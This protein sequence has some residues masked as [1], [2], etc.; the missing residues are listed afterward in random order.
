[1]W[2]ICSSTANSD[3]ACSGRAFGVMSFDEVMGRNDDAVTISELIHY[4][5]G[6][7]IMTDP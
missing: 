1:M 3:P 6:L 4:A 5:R 7:E 2:I